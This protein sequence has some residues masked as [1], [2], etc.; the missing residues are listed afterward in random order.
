MTELIK[1]KFAIATN[2]PKFAARSGKMPETLKRGVRQKTRSGCGFERAFRSP[3]WIF[4]TEPV[5][6]EGEMPGNSKAHD[7][8]EGRATGWVKSASPL[9][10]ER[11]RT[12][13][14]F[15]YG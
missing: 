15:R 13:I 9:R 12:E 1:N 7:K 8:T 4:G 14:R 5:A 3:R 6:R 2:A 10:A 11:K